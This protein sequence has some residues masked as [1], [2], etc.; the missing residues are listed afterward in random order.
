MAHP[1]HFKQE[2]GIFVPTQPLRHRGEEY[3]EKGFDIL[4]RMQREHFWYR[5][6]HKL[7]W[8]VL[9]KEIPKYFGPTPKL[10]AID[11]GGGCAGWIEYIHAHNPHMFQELAVGDSSKR[12]LLLAEP[13]VGSFAA[14]YQVDLLNMPWDE[15]WDVIFLLDVLEHI[16][17]HEEALRQVHKSLR[18][19][20]LLVV[21]TP[22]LRFFWTYND[23]LAFH[24]R[25]YS[26]RDFRMLGEQTG[27]KLLRAEY[28]MFFLSP[29]LLLSR[30]LFR[31][32]KSLTA[33]EAQAYLART[34]QVPPRPINKALTGIFSLES[35]LVNHV[36][37]PWGTSVLALLQK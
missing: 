36:N 14:R 21:T 16:P 11:V 37:F 23:E 31:P 34:H 26:K 20:G 30:L 7:I 17:E 9:E 3:D 15:E 22:A 5:G 13:V 35:F 4:L 8:T 27:F 33:E 32:P 28:F 24:Q 2:Q 18:P 1:P 6:R 29:I 12:A 25:R 10:R 19:G